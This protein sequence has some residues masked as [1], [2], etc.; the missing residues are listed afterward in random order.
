MRRS[1][2]VLTVTALAGAVVGVGPAG[3][4]AVGTV[5]QA[6]N[7]GALAITVSQA[8]FEGRS[9]SG[10]VVTD[11]D[12]PA[13]AALATAFA[14]GAAGRVP[15]LF[16]DSGVSDSLVREEITR[17]TGGP[18]GPG[19]PTVWLAGVAVDGLDGYDV[20]Q[21]GNSVTQVTA[22]V[23]ESGP[24]AG[25]G[26]R[27]LL[28]DPDDWRA[29]VIAAGFGAAY[30]VPVLAAGDLPAGLAS[31]PL[32]VGIA[33]GSVSVPANRFSRIDTI[34]GANASALSAAA[35]D[36]LVHK[37]FPAGA[38]V[39]ARPVQP[40]TADGFGP[41]AGAALLAPVVAAALHANGATAPVLLV[42]G[43]PAADAAAACAAGGR[44]GASMCAVAKADGAT[45]VLALTAT[46]RSDGAAAAGRLPATGGDPMARAALL[47]VVVALIS[48]RVRRVAR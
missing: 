40:V 6:V 21:L 13:I 7:D 36:A 12:E 42:D 22:S 28:F 27:V 23:I 26:G 41:R 45:T 31:A 20:R 44:D 16:A 48:T 15:L 5:V 25:T 3:A 29:G 17:V 34:E 19:Q 24:G 1:L 18:D 2:T 30:G 9:A 46:V 35:A 10:V 38:A 39:S 43:R 8:Y 4:G 14:G 37:E 47:L 32:P 11:A 33:M